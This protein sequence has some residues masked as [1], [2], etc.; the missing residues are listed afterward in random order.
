MICPNG[1]VNNKDFYLNGGGVAAAGA[2]QGANA[3]PSA[4][5]V[6]G[7]VTLG[8]TDS[9]TGE[10]PT[11]VTISNNANQPLEI[12][13]TVAGTQ[14]F[15][16]TGVGVLQLFPAVGSNTFTA[17]P[18]VSAGI[19]EGNTAGF[20]TDIINNA[21]VT[22]TQTTLGT[23]PKVISGTGNVQKQGN[24]RLIFSGANM[25]AGGT[26]VLAGILEGTTTSLF[27]LFAL[28]SGTTLNFNQG[29]NGTFTGSLSGSGTLS[30]DSSAGA[31]VI[32]FSQDAPSFTGPVLIND[33]SVNNPTLQV[34][35]V[36]TFAA[37]SG[38]NIFAG[39]TFD[40]NN[41]NQHIKDLT[42]AGNITLGN[43]SALLTV[44]PISASTT[45][46]GVISGTGT[47]GVAK[48]GGN[49]LILSGTNTYQGP[50]SVNS[51][52]GTLRMGTTN[53]IATSSSLHV[54]DNAIFDLNNFSQSIKDLTGTS[55][56]SI[57]LGSSAVLTVNPVSA[58]TTFFGVISG[59]GTAGLTKAGT[60]TLIL[61]GVNTYVGP[62]IINMTGGILRA[63]VP[64][65]IATSSSLTVN[66]A[67]TFDLNNFSQSIKD[68]SGAGSIT[69]GN[70]NAILTVNPV[71][72]STTFSGVISGTGTAGVTKAGTNTLVLSGTNTYL[73]PTTI[74]SSGGIL[75]AG[76]VNTIATSSGLAVNSSGT[77]DL[78]SFAQSIQDL[79]GTGAITLGAATL[80]VNPVSASTTFSG[81]ISGAGGVT[82]TGPNTLVMDGTNSYLGITTVSGG[83]LVGNTA[84]I[85]G[86]ALNNATLIFNQNVSATYAATLSGAGIF[87]KQGSAVLSF[88][89]AQ[90]QGNSFIDAGTLN[91]IASTFTTT[92]L[93]VGSGTFLTGS[94]TIAGP[95]TVLGTVSPG[96]SIGIINGTSFSFGS[97]STLSIQVDNTASSQVN[98]TGSFAI[99]PG[100]TLQVVPISGGPFQTQY[101]IVTANPVSGTFSNVVVT[102]PIF[103][104][105]V[106]YFT[107]SIVLILA[108]RT[109]PV[110]PINVVPGN[111]GQVLTAL[112]GLNPFASACLTN[113][114][115]S[116]NVTSVPIFTNQL[117][118]LQPALFNAFP[119]S[120]ESATIALRE[121]ISERLENARY[122]KCC[123][124]LP[125]C[126]GVDV[127]VAPFGDFLHQGSINN[128]PGFSTETGGI[129]FG[130]DY[131]VNSAFLVGGSLAY[132][133]SALQIGSDNPG[134]G[135]GHTNSGYAMFYSTVWQ[136][137]FYLDLSLLGGVSG[138]D[139]T[140]RIKFNSSIA[141]VN[142]SPDHN[143]IGY[144]GAAHI[145]IGAPL[146]PV[147]CLNDAWF[148]PYALADYIFIHETSY[149]E[150]GGDCLNLDVNSKNSD[151]LRAEE[152]FL[153]SSCKIYSNI[154]VVPEVRVAV[155]EEWRFQGK[156]TTSHFDV[157]DIS[158]KV[159]G[160]FP[161]RVLFVPG[162]G[163]TTYFF[164]NQSILSV[165][166]DGEFA[167]HYRD[168]KAQIEYSH[169]F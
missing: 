63:G 134:G 157:G 37:A 88:N 163:V 24:A 153:L 98:A 5:V 83:T 141:S 92:A 19:L 113:F 76:I 68:L 102:S 117:N 51:G 159:K 52:G 10:M 21:T 42:G 110:F 169:R 41:V 2:L 44:S 82:K 12:T 14:P 26:S 142:T 95:T 143:N 40:L 35:Q 93:T 77:F 32:Q 114:F 56:S 111:G 22:F 154:T 136:D 58:S 74:N 106:E 112:L 126:S 62:T 152:G 16:K 61:R 85:P 17:T 47:A 145:G 127:W 4:A 146:G 101:I 99:S 131:Q 53:S 46:S 165:K 125:F 123:D 168:V 160:I 18:T 91:L 9:G 70:T 71:S 11:A 43:M 31:P 28:T 87:R 86:N 124:D 137:D 149:K 13:G 75:R 151:L 97:G 30:I 164:C 65:T 90:S 59:S 23:Y 132:S 156:N 81:G 139:G 103:N 3:S 147:G 155:A 15:T 29:V 121:V 158:F 109:T 45:F 73:G 49:I 138:F 54:D 120:E 1:T 39:G 33:N 94:G 80:T 50:T 167:R 104:A 60:N 116:F 36:D 67:G 57:T 133:Y 79:S 96:N 48:G 161:R 7:N 118:Q 69:L 20:P 140:R 150:H 66:S 108:G 100:A 148:T 55:L 84:S 78:N 6:Q 144:E 8:W 115:E 129:A 166:V 162:I 27:G 105:T 119:L 135:K 64:N 34:T 122:N 130:C 25:Y 72:A 107:N 128:V 38:L 89:S